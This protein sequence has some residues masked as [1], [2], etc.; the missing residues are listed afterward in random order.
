[1]LWDGVPARPKAETNRR[2]GGPGDGPG[3]ARSDLLPA[4]AGRGRGWVEQN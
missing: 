3:M 2:A 1:M 4:L